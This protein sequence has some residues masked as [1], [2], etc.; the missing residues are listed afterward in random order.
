MTNGGTLIRRILA[1]NG[2]CQGSFRWR[3][4]LT[5]AG[6]RFCP[7][8][9][10]RE[11]RSAGGALAD[12]RSSERCQPRRPPTVSKWRRCQ[13]GGGGPTRRMMTEGS[14]RRTRPGAHARTAL[15]AVRDRP[16]AVHRRR[17]RPAGNRGDPVLGPTSVV[18]PTCA[19]R[20]RLGGRNGERTDR[21]SVR[22][23]D[24]IQVWP[25]FLRTYRLAR[26]AWCTGPKFRTPPTA[27]K[28]IV[29][30]NGSRVGLSM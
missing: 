19:H 2:R 1:P 23:G 27:P 24:E 20:R 21:F 6:R 22:S 25:N 9:H 8:F 4:V 12:G 26:S 28:A 18:L 14:G 7:P 10:E 3:Q 29:E 30:P 11:S 13:P 16:P 5:M 15:R 17:R